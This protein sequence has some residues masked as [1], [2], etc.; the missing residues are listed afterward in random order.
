MASS[1]H[2]T[3]AT[4]L[5]VAAEDA[6][7]APQPTITREPAKA[8]P[9]I[10]MVDDE[11]L[12][13]MA[14]AMTLEESGYEVVEAG[15]G[16]D[17]LAVVES[18]ATPDLLITDHLMPGMTG[19]ALAAQV[20]QAHPALPILMVTGYANL[21]DEDRKGIEVIGKP[22]RFDELAS[23]VA[24]LLGVDCTAAAAVT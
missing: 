13:R 3:T 11:I 2:G 5:L 24:R 19:A 1:E 12:V 18:G 17:A 9:T 22:V 6:A 15:S 16:T 10:L 23:R 7:P 8:R 20:R 21:S 14:L 4:L